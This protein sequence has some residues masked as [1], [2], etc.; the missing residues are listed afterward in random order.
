M[1]QNLLNDDPRSP[2]KIAKL[3]EKAKHKTE[4]YRPKPDDFRQEYGDEVVDADN[5]EQVKI[6]A[7]F[8]KQAA[9]LDPYIRE[10]QEM[11]NK[12]AYI[13]ECI[14]GD[15]LSGEWLA[16]KGKCTPTAKIEDYTKGVDMVIEFPQDKEPNTYLG[17]GIDITTS[18]DTQDIRAKLQR[19]FK[20]DVERG[21]VTQL[22]Y[23]ESDEI[24]E[25]IH[26]PRAVV[27]LQDKYLDSLFRAEYKNDKESL[28]HDTAQLIVL[29]QL[30]QQCTTFFKI[31]ERKEMTKLMNHYGRAQRLITEI[32]E[33]KNDLYAANPNILEDP[34]TME[35]WRFCSEKEVEMGVA[36]DVTSAT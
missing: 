21:A 12:I 17:L 25:T 16:G 1:N 19:I 4:N 11:K 2:E 22:K 35:I 32:I 27:A 29:Y 36:E 34:S 5:R 14:I 28:A 20:N 3:L 15:Q 10:R 18:K 9:K 23:F 24:K 31:A 26:V 6:E 30:Q 7:S 13:A 8:E 33:E